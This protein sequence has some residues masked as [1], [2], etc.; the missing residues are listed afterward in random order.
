[1]ARSRKVALERPLDP[2]CGTTSRR[3]RCRERLVLLFQQAVVN[4][5]NSL[6][7]PMLDHDFDGSARFPL[8][9]RPRA[10]GTSLLLAG[11]HDTSAP[12]G[13][14]VV[15]LYNGKIDRPGIVGEALSVDELV[16]AAHGARA[17]EHPVLAYWD[18]TVGYTDQGIGDTVYDVGPHGLHGS[19]RN[20][21][22][23]R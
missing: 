3:V 9:A 1:M 11:C 4:A 14:Q 15:E 7:G 12:A 10:A 20:V 21:P 22:C 23:G 19:V 16:A 5:Y 18:T 13:A 17:A 8:S 2:G 6:L